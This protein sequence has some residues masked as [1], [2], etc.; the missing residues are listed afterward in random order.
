MRKNINRR[1][2]ILILMGISAIACNP[3]NN[4]EENTTTESKEK[5]IAPDS[6]RVFRH[7]SVIQVKPSQ[8]EEYKKMH[9]A[10][11]PDVLKKISACHIHNYSIFHKDGYLFS[12]FEYT[13]KDFEADMRLMAADSLTKKWW[14]VTDPMQEPLPSR[15]EGEWWASM[16]EVFHHK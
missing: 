10:V 12:Y 4:Q 8:L 5:V 13:G 1:I 3:I 6:V 7:G 16:E 11:W 15:K 2:W 14:K 9:A